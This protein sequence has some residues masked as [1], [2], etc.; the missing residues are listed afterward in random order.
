MHFLRRQGKCV[1]RSDR[2]N[3]YAY[4]RDAMTS[5]VP[6]AE[7][8]IAPWTRETALFLL[9]DKVRRDAL[10]AWNYSAK[11]YQGVH[12]DHRATIDKVK[13]DQSLD[14]RWASWKATTA[15]FRANQIAKGTAAAALD[16]EMVNIKVETG[17]E[18]SSG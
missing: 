14:S 2:M 11:P 8:W 10:R 15:A 5:G 18:G 3:L 9:N 7:K 6:N 17:L 4:W 16:E 13:A 12:L 1:I